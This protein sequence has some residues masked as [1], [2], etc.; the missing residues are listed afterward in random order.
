MFVHEPIVYDVGLEGNRRQAHSAELILPIPDFFGGKLDASIFDII[1]TGWNIL[2]LYLF[3]LE[4]ANFD[5]I[6]FEGKLFWIGV[7]DSD[8]CFG[9]GWIV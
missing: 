4:R 6:G 7:D 3:G 5:E 1:K 2:D 9:A 8:N